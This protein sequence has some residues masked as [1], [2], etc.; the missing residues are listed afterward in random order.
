MATDTPPVSL[1]ALGDELL[2]QARGQPAGRAA[3]TVT[4]AGTALR[5]VVLAITAGQRLQDH[6]APGPATLQ[7]LRGRVRVTVD[8]GEQAL[9]AGEWAPIPDAVHGL[10]A[11]EDAVALLSVGGVSAV[12]P[13]AD[14]TRR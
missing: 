14:P 6:H 8:G 10:V 2:E 12:D 7:V 5:Q 11:D 4:A 13:E 9:E 3:R 1:A